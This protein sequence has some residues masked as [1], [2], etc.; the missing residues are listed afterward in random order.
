MNRHG[1]EPR[2]ILRPHSLKVKQKEK[3]KCLLWLQ[4]VVDYYAINPSWIL[5]GY[6]GVDLNEVGTVK[7]SS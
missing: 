1:A 5:L 2:G 6:I 7:E 4:V 3:L